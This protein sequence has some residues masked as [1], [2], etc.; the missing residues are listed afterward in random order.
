[1]NATPTKEGSKMTG[2]RYE[3]KELDKAYTAASRTAR[4]AADA[5]RAAIR[6][7][8]EE[9]KLPRGSIMGWAKHTRIGVSI[10]I[11][12]PDRKT[13]KG[14]RVAGG[15]ES[16]LADMLKGLEL[17]KGTLE[18]WANHKAYRKNLDFAIDLS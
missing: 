10:Y 7:L 11:N 3:G 16:V 15:V 4:R 1:M 18:V 6:Q 17:P 2:I 9:G 5:I 13:D 14:C 12:V 8:R